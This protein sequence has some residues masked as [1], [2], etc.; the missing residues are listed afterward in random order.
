MARMWI[1]LQKNVY[2][3][4]E[5]ISGNVRASVDQPVKQRSATVYLLGKERTQI[6]YQRTVQ[7][8][9]TAQT[10]T[11]TAV[12]ESEFLHQEQP[13]PLPLDDKGKFRVGDHTFP[14]KFL[15]QQGLPTTYRGRQAA[16]QYRIYA[17]V[18]VPMGGDVDASSE[19]TVISS[20]AQ[21]YQSAPVN[22]YSNSWGNAQSTG[23]SFTLDKA[24]Y[25]RGEAI[26]GRCI[27]RNP[28]GKDLR[29]LDISL[30]W[31]ESAT[32]QNQRGSTE[33][34][35]ELAQAQAGGRSY[36]GETTFSINVPPQAPPTYEATLSNV[37]CL[38]TVSMDVA[39][40]L[41]VAASQ[42]IRVVETPGY[43]GQPAPQYTPAPQYPAAP[44]Y[45]PGPQYPVAPPP[46]YPPAPQY[47]APNVAGAR[48]PH[49]GA[50][51]T[52][53][54]SQYCPACGSRLQI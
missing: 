19:F 12:Q 26:T 48:C 41:D 32:A 54:G 27:Y 6:N 7:T 25:G 16:I 11:E 5:E 42:N 39:M 4:G 37:R 50:P 30:R 24:Q 53:P 44:Q 51:I 36:Q 13:M 8:G 17:K 52:K 15:L 9:S 28:S 49:C 33:V 47:P 18:D 3:L 22:A 14:F 23:L 45:P 35:R 43:G 21:P 46:Q 20:G 31:V 38:L 29:K 10:R 2:S 1:E 40:G 34:L